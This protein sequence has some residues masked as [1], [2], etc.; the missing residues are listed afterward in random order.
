VQKY[1]GD[2]EHKAVVV[3]G[4]RTRIVRFDES[5]KLGFNFFKKNWCNYPMGSQNFRVFL[6]GGGSN[7]FEIEIFRFLAKNQ[8]KIDFFLKI[9]TLA[10]LERRI[11]PYP[12]L[13]IFSEN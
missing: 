8:E 10:V 7:V 13:A 4:A 1:L 11:F 2:D 5:R 9:L 3:F 12:L 6:G